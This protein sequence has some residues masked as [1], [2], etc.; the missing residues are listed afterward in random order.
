[1]NIQQ[2]RQSLSGELRTDDVTRIA[3]STDASA[4]QQEPL[5][6]AFPKHESDI[7]T[8]VK[9]A[10]QHG[11]GLIPRTAGTSLAGQVVGDG[12]VVD[13][14]RHFQRILQIDSDSQSVLVQPG[15]IRNELN[16]A[17]RPHSM[18]FG[19]ETSTQNRAMMGGMLGNNSC[20]SN[21]I[22]F[23]S[24]RD[25]ILQVR[26][27][28]S[29]GSIATFGELDPSGFE[30]ACGDGDGER[31]D[32]ANK[33]LLQR[34]YGE[35]RQLLGNVQVRDSI[36]G[37]FPKPTVLRRNTGYA[38]DALMDAS[39]FDQQSGAPFNFC[40]LIAGSEGTLCFVT[41]MRLRCLPLPPTE[42]GLM[43]IHFR[44]VDAAL[45]A[46]QIAVT[47]DCYA[48]ELMDHHILDATLRS[49]QHRE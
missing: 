29:D 38:L 32:A 31:G 15:V 28:L 20:G 25:H 26:A 11:V 2:L 17:L 21:S 12:I 39:C 16:A 46:T 14:S 27:V 13:V 45:R 1:M 44:S 42:S 47:H 23:G 40:K 7:I 9:F 3:Y 6:V 33:P 30:S 41:Q 10:G 18:W 8:L 22:K 34:L 37:G 5:A 49:L 48:C 24:V 4:Y 19:P 43:C 35:T 36:R